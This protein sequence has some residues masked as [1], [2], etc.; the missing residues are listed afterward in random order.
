MLNWSSTSAS[1]IGVKKIFERNVQKENLSYTVRC[2]LCHKV[3]RD[4][5]IKNLTWMYV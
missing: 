2:F 5:V 4:I 3:V 1:I